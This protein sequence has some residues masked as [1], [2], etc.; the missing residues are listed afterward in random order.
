MRIAGMILRWIGPVALVLAAAGTWASAQ[1]RDSARE[2]ADKS[3]ARVYRGGELT[4]TFAGLRQTNLDILS[5]H[6]TNLSQ[7][8]GTE[9][10]GTLG[11]PLLVLLDMK[12]DHRDGL[13]S[14]KFDPPPE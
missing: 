7:E 4:L 8:S 1:A 11:F 10:S 12:I 3:V 14:F 2:T 5:I 6:E 13:V 9:I